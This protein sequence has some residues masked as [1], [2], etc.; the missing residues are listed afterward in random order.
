MPLTPSGVLQ[1]T[2]TQKGGCKLKAK[3]KKRPGLV[4]QLAL[5]AN[6]EEVRKFELIKN[7]HC[8]KSDSDMLRFLINQEAG[9]ILP[10][11][12]TKWCR[13]RRVK[14]GRYVDH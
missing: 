4:R 8:R 6:E 11:K 3:W 2:D 12:Y 9:K 1:C 5:G 14:G 7:F 10:K 13:L